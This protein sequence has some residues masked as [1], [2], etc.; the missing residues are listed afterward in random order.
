MIHILSHTNPTLPTLDTRVTNENSF[1]NLSKN[2]F[3][4]VVVT[5]IGPS[6]SFLLFF[7]SGN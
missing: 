7:L 4:V 3:V 2:S 1:S 5:A 6:F